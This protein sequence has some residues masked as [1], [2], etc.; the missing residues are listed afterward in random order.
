MYYTDIIVTYNQ[1]YGYPESWY[2]KYH[3]PENLQ[4]DGNFSYSLTKFDVTSD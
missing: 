1:D 3:C 2:Y 4:V